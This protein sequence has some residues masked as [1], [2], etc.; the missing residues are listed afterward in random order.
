MGCCLGKEKKSRS[1]RSAGNDVQY[2]VYH[3]STRKTQEYGSQI[4]LNNKRSVK[5]NKSAQSGIRGTKIPSRG[6]F[7]SSHAICLSN[8]V[9][10]A[11]SNSRSKN[12]LQTMYDH[13]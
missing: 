5:R 1:S 12:I 11:Q 7:E 3:G 9:Y 13:N 6:R 10:V 8:D 4:E 2:T